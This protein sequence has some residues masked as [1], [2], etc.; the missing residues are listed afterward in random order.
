MFSSFDGKESGSGICWQIIY[1]LFVF[2]N[3]Q[4]YMK[5]IKCFERFIS[6]SLIKT[7]IRI[8]FREINFVLSLFGCEDFLV[9][10]FVHKWFFKKEKSR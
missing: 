10:F 5:H 9:S 7:K 8:S 3:Y 1:A 4:I 6:Y 2:L